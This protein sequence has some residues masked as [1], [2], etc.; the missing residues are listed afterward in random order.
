MQNHATTQV[1]VSPYKVRVLVTNFGKCSPSLQHSTQF[2]KHCVSDVCMVQA[3]IIALVP[4]R[5]KAHEYYRTSAKRFIHTL[6]AE[7][8]NESLC[9]YLTAPYKQHTMS[10]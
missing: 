5:V 4:I 6:V 1:L 10:D 2:S 7:Y 8:T 9:R 3:S